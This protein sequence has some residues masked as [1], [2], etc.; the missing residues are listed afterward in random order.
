[1]LA[2]DIKALGYWIK[3]GFKACKFFKNLCWKNYPFSAIDVRGIRFIL[4][5]IRGIGVRGV[6][7][8]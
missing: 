8:H 6:D 5:L 7:I 4:W 1:M 3:D 2:V